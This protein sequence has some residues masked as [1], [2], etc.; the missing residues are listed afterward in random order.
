MNTLLTADEVRDRLRAACAEAGSQAAWA[1]KNGVSKAWVSAVLIGL[2][3][4]SEAILTP[5]GIKAKRT[6]VSTY[7]VDEAAD[8]A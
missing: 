8:V 5:L 1:R 3:E 4:P 7:E 6:V 2:H